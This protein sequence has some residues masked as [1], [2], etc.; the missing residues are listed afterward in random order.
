MG[1]SCQ[2]QKNQRRIPAC[3]TLAGIWGA[4]LQSCSCRTV[5]IGG[6]PEML[7]AQKETHAEDV[8]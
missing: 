3:A 7:P 8:V 5:V 2:R 4:Q 6:K 1:L